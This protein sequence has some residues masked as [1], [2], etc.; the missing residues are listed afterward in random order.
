MAKEKELIKK[1]VVRFLHT[2]TRC[3]GFGTALT[4]VSLITTPLNRGL[5][6]SNGRQIEGG[7]VNRRALA[8]SWAS[9]LNTETAFCKVSG[10]GQA[11]RN[12]ASNKP[13]P[14]DSRFRTRLPNTAKASTVPRSL[15]TP[16]PKLIR[17]Q[18]M[19]KKRWP[20]PTATSFLQVDAQRRVAAPYAKDGEIE[21]LLTNAHG[22]SCP[23]HAG[24]AALGT[25]VINYKAKVST[26]S[27]E[28][29]AKPVFFGG[30]GYI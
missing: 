9:P 12:G 18:L 7:Y 5:R 13:S 15:S 21:V 22:I 19:L 1:Y 30:D 23:R 6:P 24:K 17:P 26:V 11:I 14:K 2:D 4:L 25:K 27:S 28:T 3:V 8:V 20:N 29:R 16:I 10:L